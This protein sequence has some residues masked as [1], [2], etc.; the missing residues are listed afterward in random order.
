[1]LKPI[2]RQSLKMRWSSTEVVVDLDLGSKV[3]VKAVPFL[4]SLHCEE[5]FIKRILDEL[6][7]LR[8]VLCLIRA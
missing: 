3:S 5:G 6:R 2:K 4:A 1:M 7:L 8:A